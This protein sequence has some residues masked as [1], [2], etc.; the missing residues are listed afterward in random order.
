MR[1]EQRRE[2]VLDCFIKNKVSKKKNLISIT[3]EITEKKNVL[4][5]LVSQPVN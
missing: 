2:L 4:P 5:R 3:N 1:A